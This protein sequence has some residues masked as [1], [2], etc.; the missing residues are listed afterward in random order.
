MTAGRSMCIRRSSCR[1]RASRSGTAA[2]RTPTAP[3]APPIS[4]TTTSSAIPTTMCSR[5]S[6]TRWTTCRRC[7]RE[8]G[9]DKLTI[10][11]EMDNYWFSAAAFAS[12][13][14]HLPN[15]RFV[16]ATGAG[17]LAAR[18]QE[19]DRDRLHAQGR[20]HR[21]GHARSASST[22]SRPACANAISSPRST[23]PARAASTESAATI[24]RSCRC[25]PRARMPRRRT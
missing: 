12:L 17:Q 16:D 11:V 24:R 1:R 9:W 4:R 3:S 20:P 13:Q 19:P 7:S 8:R 6:A 18:G 5:P 15:A 23:M 14:K 21:R 2:A 10:G 25:C 22:R